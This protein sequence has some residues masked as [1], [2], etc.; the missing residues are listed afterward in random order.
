MVQ[1]TTCDEWRASGIRLLKK[2]LENPNLS[3]S[4]AI[5][6]KA[7]KQNDQVA[8]PL[9]LKTVVNLACG[10]NVMLLAGT[11]FGKSQI[12]EFYHDLNPKES[13]AVI[14]VL[15]PLDALGNCQVLEKKQAGF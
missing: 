2:M 9:Q 12:S 15:N 11:G 10:R 6:N 7:I 8:K 4:A 3:L 1:S 13:K 5:A 14:V